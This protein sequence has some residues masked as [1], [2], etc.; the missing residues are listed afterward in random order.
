MQ[1]PTRLAVGGLTR[2]SSLDSAPEAS[3]SLINSPQ[4]YSAEP[5]IGSWEEELR[6]KMLKPGSQLLGPVARSLISTVRWTDKYPA[7]DDFAEELDTLLLFAKSQGRLSHFVP[8]LES[9]NTQRH[10]ALNEL[11]VAYFLHQNRFPVKEWE[12]PGLNGRVGEYL[13]GI[14]ESQDIFTELKSPGWGGELS[15]AERR[16]GRTKQ[17]KY[18]NGE[19]GAFGNWQPL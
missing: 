7:W 1:L 11:R 8:R 13:I 12:P 19:G 3:K 2:S 16:A 5:M 15:D 9:R 14:S 17:P 18:R 6:P 10:A 4:F